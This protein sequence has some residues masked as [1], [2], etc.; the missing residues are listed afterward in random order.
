MKKVILIAA[1]CI[2]SAAIGIAIGRGSVSV[3]AD[4]TSG[5][6]VTSTDGADTLTDEKS[7]IYCDEFG[8]PLPGEDNFKKWY[9]AK[10]ETVIDAHEEVE[11]LYGKILSLEKTADG[12]IR[13]LLSADEDMD[14]N[15]RQNY[16]FT[17]SDDTYLKC[18]YA[19]FDKEE[20][21]VGQRVFISFAYSHEVLEYSGEKSVSVFSL[22]VL[23]DDPRNPAPLTPE[24]YQHYDVEGEIL[25]PEDYQYY[26]VEGE[27]LVE[28]D[29][30][31]TIIV[32]DPLE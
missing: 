32:E 2:L 15:H 12:N 11:F 27:I 25:V 29:T 30:E 3:G 1:L 6:A 8:Y 13:V 31:G 16:R 21:L 7:E 4:K 19:D 5:N 9:D 17:V 18:K 10:L 20:L 22:F 24:D 14:I 28:E 23:D 26:D